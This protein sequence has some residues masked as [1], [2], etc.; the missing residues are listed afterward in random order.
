MKTLLIMRHAKSSWKSPGLTDHERPL[1]KRGQRDAQRMGKL[2]WEMGLTPDVILSSTA[3][4]ARD[5]AGLVAGAC[6][7]DGE[8]ICLQEFYPTVPEE[9]ID[10]LRNQA[11]EVGSVLVIGHNPGLEETLYLLAGADEWLPTSALAQIALP[12]EEWERLDDE[13]SGHLMNLWR[14]RELN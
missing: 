6:G 9:V 2:I 7:Y 14:P 5:T 3:R 8:I 12:V 4:R 10:V 1:K 11:A 13:T